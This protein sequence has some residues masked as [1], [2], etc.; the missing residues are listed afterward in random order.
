MLTGCNVTLHPQECERGSDGGESGLMG[1]DGW[2]AKAWRVLE[3]S[4]G[5]T[6][7]VAMF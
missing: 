7:S 2:K 1:M 3:C 6:P 5:G 4:I